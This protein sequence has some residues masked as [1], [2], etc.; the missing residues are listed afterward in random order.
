MERLE[1]L[2]YLQDTLAKSFFGRAHEQSIFVEEL[3]RWMGDDDFNKFYD[4]FCRNWEI[5]KEL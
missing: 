3:V 5:K 1:K 4:H 2:Q